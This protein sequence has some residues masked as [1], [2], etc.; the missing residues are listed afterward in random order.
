LPEFGMR[1]ADLEILWVIDR[2]EAKGPVRVTDVA[3]IL[4]FT[5]GG[6]SK[7]LDGLET[8]GLVERRAHAGDARAVDLVL[9]GEGR[10]VVRR[11]RAAHPNILPLLSEAEWLQLSELLAKL[12]AEW[13]P[14][15]SGPDGPTPSRAARP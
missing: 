10:K 1:A 11:S 15:Q 4:R 3:H 6:V 8:S 2:V 12:A 13:K 7:R 5:P 9:T 14:K